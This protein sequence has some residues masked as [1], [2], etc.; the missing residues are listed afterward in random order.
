MS[1]ISFMPGAGCLLRSDPVINKKNIRMVTGISFLTIS[2][3]HQRCYGTVH[4]LLLRHPRFP[5]MQWPLSTYLDALAPILPP[6]PNDAIRRPAHQNLCPPTALTGQK[7][8]QPNWRFR[9]PPPASPCRP[10]NV[11]RVP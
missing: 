5:L 3:V 4:A 2:Q 11:P 1:L 6:S 9:M 8:S 7:Y 10:Q